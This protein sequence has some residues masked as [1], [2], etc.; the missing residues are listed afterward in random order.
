MDYV[1]GYIKYYKLNHFW[2]KSNYN[3]RV[4]QLASINSMFI[5]QQK[6]EMIREFLFIPLSLRGK[7]HS[8]LWLGG[9]FLAAFTWAHSCSCSELDY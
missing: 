9:I 8:N 6:L 1:C 4:N 2:S 7:K 5:S 3:G